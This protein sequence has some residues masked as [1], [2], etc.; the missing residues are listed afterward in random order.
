LP[1]NTLVNPRIDL[2]VAIFFRR[3]PKFNCAIAADKGLLPK[4][5]GIF[6]RNA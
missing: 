3:E 6:D 2:Q 4:A 5:R 1:R